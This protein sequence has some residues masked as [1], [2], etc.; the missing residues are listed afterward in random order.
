[1]NKSAS[2]ARSPIVLDSLA[3]SSAWVEDQPALT[4]MA[5]VG[6]RSD[7]FTGWSIGDSQ[8]GYK[9]M[10]NCLGIVEPGSSLGALSLPDISGGSARST[11]AIRSASLY[12][13]LPPP[14]RTARNL[15]VPAFKWRWSDLLLMDS[16]RA[17]C[18]RVSRRSV[19]WYELWGTILVWSLS[20]FIS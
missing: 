16:S 8:S 13:G 19:G 12:F 4:G 11:S 6:I 10:P 18:S 17:A 9:G 2:E 7:K 3:A 14:N 1:M 20:L 5:S 15:M